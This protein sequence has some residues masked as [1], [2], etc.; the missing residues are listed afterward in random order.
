MTTKQEEKGYATQRKQEA[1]LLEAVVCDSV[2]SNLGRPEGPHR[3]KV[4][5]VWGHNYRVNVFAGPDITS[6]KIVHSY[7]VEADSNGKILKS[8]PAITRVY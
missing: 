8:F 7:F 4:T 1:G 3:I 5:C 6:F 2:L